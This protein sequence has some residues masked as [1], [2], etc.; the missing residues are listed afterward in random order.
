[1]TSLP[2]LLAG[3]LVAS[4]TPDDARKAALYP[5]LAEAYRLFEAARFDDAIEAFEQAYAISPE[6]RFVLNIAL[7][8]RAL[9]QCQ[10]AL[11]TFERFFAL[12]RDC[13]QAEEAAT[14]HRDVRA[15]C[16][17]PVRIVTEPSGAQVAVDGVPRGNAPVE[18]T[19]PAGPHVVRASAEGH[20][21]EERAVVVEGGRPATVSI[22][23]RA[24]PDL[25]PW[26]WGAFGGAAVGAVT[27]GVFGALLLDDLDDEAAAST[28]AASEAARDEARRD[29]ALAQAGL[30][31]AAHGLAAGFTLLWLDSDE[32]VTVGPTAEHGVG[33]GFRF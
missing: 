3:L 6:P 20:A 18:V 17:A 12:C 5:V 22:P 15:R 32:H 11:A 21:P 25:A 31:L 13:P 26:M 33:L 29:A 28:R 7:S 14:L 4:G 16:E 24:R 8:H 30:G 19:L 2:A 23:L 1:M 27:A 10:R 9:G